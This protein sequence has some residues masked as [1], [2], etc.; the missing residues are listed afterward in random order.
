MQSKP[1]KSCNQNLP[2]SLCDLV[3][4]LFPG[5]K[6]S[7]TGHHVI[8]ALSGGLDSSVLLH[9]TNRLKEPLANLKVSA[10]HVH[11]GISDKADAWDS[12]CEML[13]SRLAV[14]YRCLT[15]DARAGAGESPEEKARDC[16]Y[17]ALAGALGK[18]ECLLSAHHQDDQAETLLLQLLRGAGPRGLAA[19]PEVSVLGEGRLVR[20]LLGFSRQQLHDYARAHAITWVEDDSN[21]DTR[22]DRNFLRHQVVPSLKQRWP[23]MAATL[24]RA[25][26]HIAD[27]AALLDELA[28]IDLAQCQGSGASG[29][30]GA[31]EG[32]G[33]SALAGLDMR[34][35]GHLH[36]DRQRN[37]LRYWLRQLG[38]PVPQSQQMQHVLTDVLHAGPDRVPC[39]QWPGVEVRRYRE[40]LFAMPPLSLHDSHAR[41]GWNLTDP[42]ALSVGCLRSVP[43]SGKG[44]R[45]N[46]GATGVTVAFRQGGE[47]CQPAGRQHHHDL[48]K[49][50]Q[51]AGIPPWQRDR[52]PLLYVEND[53][54]AVA[55]LWVCQQFAAATNEAG[56]ELHWQAS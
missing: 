37:L 10:V 47:V 49:L 9:A 34:A 1:V 24:S 44:L 27:S 29:G 53:L 30:A 41:Y 12:H 7:D 22:L 56:L 13:C 16:R 39:V 35:L 6:D 28:A 19:M 45:A 26:G 21:A 11:H 15:V 14:P 54:A 32:P 8:V 3:C 43:V 48:K 2:D 20:P 51:E 5:I 38:L 36:S 23:A 33:V 25:A 18:G 42:L 31:T 4:Q 40:R 52:I 17:R 46:L 55:G 50:F